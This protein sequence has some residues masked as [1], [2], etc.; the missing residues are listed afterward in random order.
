MPVSKTAA[1][2]RDASSNHRFSAS[3]TSVARV[4]TELRG[5]A[6]RHLI[7]RRPGTT[8]DTGSLV[9]EA[10][11]KVMGPG[12]RHW[13]DRGHFLAVASTAMRHIII[14]RAIRQRTVKHGGE[15]RKVSLDERRVMP[16]DQADELLALNEALERLATLDA[17]LGQVVECR[18]FGGLSVPE[19]A[20]ALGCSPRTV[21][22]A[23]QKAKA[24]LYRELKRD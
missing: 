21:D 13:I 12:R 18:F 1:N 3:D 8:I 22:R 11:L 19:T 2:R 6:H 20:V 10:Y 24:W 16:D 4:Y 15:W 7:A 17:R 23:W 9:H 5:I 14:D